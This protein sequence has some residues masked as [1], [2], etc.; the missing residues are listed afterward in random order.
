MERRSRNT[1]IIVVVVVVVAAAAA[2]VVAAVVVVVVVV[3]IEVV[4]MCK[5]FVRPTIFTGTPN[6]VRFHCGLCGTVFEEV[7]GF[8]L[9]CGLE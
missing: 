1:L 2:V 6:P 3:I 4:Q 5:R 7:F 8:W 9:P